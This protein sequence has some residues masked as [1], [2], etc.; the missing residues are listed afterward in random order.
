MLSGQFDLDFEKKA[1]ELFRIQA[2]ENPIYNAYLQG[3]R[4][5]PEQ[6]Q[7]LNQIPFMP[8]RFFKEHSVKSGNWQ[9]EAIFTSSGTTGVEVSKHYVFSTERYLQRCET[10]FEHFYG[11]VE[12]W[13]ILA[14]LPSYL[15]REGSSLIVMVQH[16]IEK[17]KA[18]ES[19]FF[20]HDLQKLSETLKS[21]R[22]REK[23]LLLGV[24]FA[25]LDFAT[26]FPGDYSNL[27]VM[28]TGGMKGRRKEMTRQEIHSFLQSGFNVPQIHS[29]YGMTEL[30]T[31]AYS[32]GS[33]QFY[34]PPGMQVFIR[35]INDPFDM[36]PARNYGVICVIDLANEK[37]CAFIETQDLGSLH[38][39]GSFSVLGRMDNA[40]VRGCNL[41]VF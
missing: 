25:L 21:L 18:K 14:L 6:V 32:M 34:C 20:L 24:T 38:P 13:T 10:C 33:G 5:R 3:L 30:F 4:I 12:D 23:V 40:E 15:E 22:K 17:T 28:E 29:E 37:T 27:I 31:Q 36:Q 35:D 39:D 26:Q 1:L 9:H 8:I 7:H 2:Q 19:D 16:F 11:A 41:M